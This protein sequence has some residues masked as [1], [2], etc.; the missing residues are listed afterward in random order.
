MLKP[1]LWDKPDNSLTADN[2]PGLS[3]SGTTPRV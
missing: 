3:E 2:R 1:T